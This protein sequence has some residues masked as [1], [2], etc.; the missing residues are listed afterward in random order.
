MNTD[1]I[2]KYEQEKDDGN[3]EV[4]AEE[5]KEVKGG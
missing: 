5:V 3:E 4:V 1:S 2:S